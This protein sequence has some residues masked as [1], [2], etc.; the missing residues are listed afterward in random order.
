VEKRINIKNKVPKAILFD[1]GSTLLS[2]SMSG[3]LSMR[4]RTHLK[5]DT[6]KP[7][8]E[9]GFDLPVELAAAMDGMYRDGLE[10]FRLRKWL[11]SHLIWKHAGQAGSMERIIRSTIISY[12]PPKDASRVLRALMS[13]DIPMGVVSN[14]IFSAD[15]LRNDLET[16]SVPEAF[17]FVI[18]SAE[19]GLRKPHPQIFKDAVKQLGAEPSSTWYV[20]DLWENDVMGST[21]AGLIPVWLHAHATAPDVSVSHLRVKNWTELG[22]LVGG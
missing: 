9:K 8:V 21:G 13:L 22:E 14:S 12:S 7:F 15:L 17:S 11:E 3:G 2:D 18:S 6:F 10:E 20:G 16:L 19:F 5:N 1:L 4:V